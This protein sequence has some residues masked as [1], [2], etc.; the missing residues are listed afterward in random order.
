LEKIKSHV[1]SK[2]IALRDSPLAELNKLEAVD[3][4]DEENEG[5]VPV[6]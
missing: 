1:K 2:R 5:I 4:D 6:A 3:V